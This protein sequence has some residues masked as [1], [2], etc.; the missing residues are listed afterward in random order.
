MP[1]TEDKYIPVTESGCWI[2]LKAVASG[3]G[4]VKVKGK[5]QGAHRVMYE[6]EIGEIP[7]GLHILHTCDCKLCVNPAHL[8]AG[9]HKKNMDDM[10]VRK[11]A[12]GIKYTQEFRET[13]TQ[14]YLNGE[15][16]ASLA[17]EYNIDFRYLSEL[18][19]AHRTNTA[20]RPTR[21]RH[22]NKDGNWV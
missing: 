5:M 2:W 8:Y 15:T 10:R 21:K 12:H 3:Y 22:K 16:Q 6:Q 4:S 17:K 20:I 18:I 14:R 19:R 11:R 9:T 1:I 7:E 13:L